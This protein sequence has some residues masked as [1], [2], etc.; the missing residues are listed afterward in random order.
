MPP[1]DAHGKMA[2]REPWQFFLGRWVGTSS[3][4]PGDG[5]SEREYKLVLNNQFIELRSRTIFEPQARNPGGEIHEEI[6]YISYDQNRRAFIL[7]EFHVEG[8]VNQYLMQEWAP[9]RNLLVLAT[10]AIENFAPGWQARIT[11]EIL[12]PDRFRES[13]DLAGPD[14]DWNCMVVSELDRVPGDT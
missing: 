7:R 3:G 13:F 1:D 2:R 14:Q 11:Y 6:G 5:R 10:E 9:E 4:K 12:S 8:Y